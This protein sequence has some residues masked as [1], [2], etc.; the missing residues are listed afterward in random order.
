MLKSKRRAAPAAGPAVSTRVKSTIAWSRNPF[1]LLT[2]PLSHATVHGSAPTFAEGFG[3]STVARVASEGGKA[4]AERSP[5]L[6]ERSPSGRSIGKTTRSD[7]IVVTGS[8]GARGPSAY[9]VKP[10]VNFRYWSLTSTS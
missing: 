8:D 1:S 6:L 9:F 7:A 3:A 10:R 4:S 5:A 2:R